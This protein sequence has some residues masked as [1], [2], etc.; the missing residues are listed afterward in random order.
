M[1]AGHNT[2]GTVQSARCDCAAAVN[3]RRPSTEAPT[4]SGVISTEPNPNRGTTDIIVQMQNSRDPRNDLQPLNVRSEGYALLGSFHEATQA[5]SKCIEAS[6]PADVPKL[7]L[8]L[9][10]HVLL[11]LIWHQGR[12]VFLTDLA[13]GMAIS[14]GWA[15]RIIDEL[16]VAELATRLHNQNDR[17]AVEL[18]VTEKG[19][20]VAARVWAK[21]EQPFV[22]ALVYLSPEDRRIVKRFLQ[23]TTIEL[24]KRLLGEMKS[25]KRKEQRMRGDARLGRSTEATS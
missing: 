25:R 24:R 20:E 9:S 14:L 18:R 16:V 13:H 5:A 10:V 23:R 11:Y 22:A 21:L 4:S 19:Q 3:R 8:T 12:T 2:C 6:V 1:M 15:S 7:R 17:R